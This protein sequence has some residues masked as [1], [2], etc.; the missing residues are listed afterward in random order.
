[1][2]T[3]FRSSSSKKN[4]L[5]DD[6]FHN[7]MILESVLN[8]S[9]TSD[10]SV[11]RK[12][13]RKYRKKTDPVHEFLKLLVFNKNLI[14][15]DDLDSS[16]IVNFDNDIEINE[17]IEEENKLF[18]KEIENFKKYS[19]LARNIIKGTI[20]LKNI[21]PVLKEKKRKNVFENVFIKENKNNCFQTEKYENEN[22]IIPTQNLKYFSNNN[23]NNLNV[24]LEETKSSPEI[25]KINNLKRTYKK[26]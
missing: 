6:Y 25:K 1:M 11:V 2:S 18:R 9:F 17:I 15:S 19:V 21:Q 26:K 22:V 20:F 13:S 5:S 24:I 7:K 14:K 10:C 16:L 4:L 8:Q 3:Q 12:K 23:K